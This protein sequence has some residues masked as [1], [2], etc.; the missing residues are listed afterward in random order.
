[1]YW[2]HAITPLHVGSGRGVEFIDMP[3]IREKITNWPLVPGSAVKGVMRDH[4]K[5]NKMD[6]KLIDAAFGKGGDDTG[7]AGSLVLTDAH[8]VCMPIRSLYGTFAYVT[9]PMVLERL[10]RDLETASYEDL[11]DS[12]K[13]A[14]N[15][16]LHISG[17]KLVDTGKVYFEDLDFAAKLDDNS[18]KKWAEILAEQLFS[19]ETQWRAIFKERFA[20]VTDDSFNFLAETGT[21]VL[22][23]VKIK[24]ETKIVEKGALWYEESLPA[25][26]VLA[27]IAWCDRLYGG[28]GIDQAKILSTFYPE[29][30]LKLQIGGKA[31]VGKGR[32]RC[33]FT[34][35]KA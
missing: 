5:Q 25:E 34:R 10:R 27:G 7:N 13:P 32:A 11:P 18:T 30:G 19:Q 20:V 15:E 8:I 14:K 33:M 16:A 2:L 9:C 21:E 31:T 24:D 28:N 1:M 26:T 35:G 3:I 22:A 12:P 29:V 17:S 6:E 4:F 23:H